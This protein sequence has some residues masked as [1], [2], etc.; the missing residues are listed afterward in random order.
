MSFSARERLAEE[1]DVRP[2]RT[3]AL[4]ACRRDRQQAVVGDRLA[5]PAPRA[6]QVVQ[7]AVDVDHVAGPGQPVQPVDVLRQRPDPL[8][9]PLHLGD[10]LM[11]AVVPHAAAH[12]LDLRE[13]LPRQLRMVVEQVARERPLDAQAVLRAVDVVRQAIAAIG[14]QPGI[15]RDARPR[16]EQN[17]AT[18][19]QQLRDPV[20]RFLMIGDRIQR[21]PEPDVRL[22]I[23]MTRS[24]PK[25][26]L[27]MQFPRGSPFPADLR[28][29]PPSASWL[30]TPFSLPA[31]IL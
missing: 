4:R 26:V 13:V 25:T 29:R 17:A 9:V 11:G 22:R 6:A 21:G 2:K 19:G 18:D 12:P 27:D 1:H 15:H 3:R 14:R 16:D 5:V 10:D 8:E 20:D 7:V 24:V 23:W 31:C 30:L 28:R